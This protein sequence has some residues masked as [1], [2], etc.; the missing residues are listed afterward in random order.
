[1]VQQSRREAPG[2]R[3]TLYDPRRTPGSSR[4]GTA[5]AGAAAKVRVKTLT[6]G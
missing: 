2:Y 5:A 4:G 1:M 6:S 3:A